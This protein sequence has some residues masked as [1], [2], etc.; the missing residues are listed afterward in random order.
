MGGFQLLFHHICVVWADASVLMVYCPSVHRHG[1]GKRLSVNIDS[2]GEDD[3]A[4][5]CLCRVLLGC[6]GCGQGM[7]AP[8]WQLVLLQ[9]RETHPG[10]TRIRVVTAAR[11][12][13]QGGG[14]DRT[15]TADSAARVWKW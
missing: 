7:D 13:N 1:H 10:S 8:Q 15:H 3:C 4:C 5:I 9:G 2:D 6:G 11:L 12:G 14:R